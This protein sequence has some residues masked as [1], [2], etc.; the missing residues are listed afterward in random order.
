[1]SESNKITQLEK[2]KVESE[3]RISFLIHHN[4]KLRGQLEM[5]DDVKKRADTDEESL[6]VKA[7]KGL[8]IPVG[9]AVVLA[10]VFGRTFIQLRYSLSEFFLNYHIH[11]TCSSSLFNLYLTCFSPFLVKLSPGKNVSPIISKSPP[12]LH[13]NAN[14]SQTHPRPTPNNTINRLLH[15]LRNSPLLLLPLRKSKSS[16]TARRIAPSEKR[17]GGWQGAC[18]RSVFAC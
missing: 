7:V 10:V 17:T 15:P 5:S 6:L 8:V 18:W 16:S 9:L 11:P 3:L 1:M 14:P 12:F 2:E 13:N 4:Q